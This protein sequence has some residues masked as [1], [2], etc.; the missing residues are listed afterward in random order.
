M[1]MENSGMG[2]VYPFLGLF[3]AGTAAIAVKTRLP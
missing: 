2:E 1:T 3:L